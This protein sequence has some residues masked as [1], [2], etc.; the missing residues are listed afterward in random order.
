MIFKETIMQKLTITS[1]LL[2]FGLLAMSANADTPKDD[3]A[4]AHSF[5]A[6]ML[7]GKWECVGHYNDKS[8]KNTSYERSLMHFTDKGNYHYDGFVADDMNGIQDVIDMELVGEYKIEGDIFLLKS[9]K[10]LRYN[11]TNPRYNR[12]YNFED[13]LNNSPKFSRYQIVRLTDTLFENRYLPDMDD[14][15]DDSDITAYGTCRRLA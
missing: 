4:T 8:L 2:S 12:L 6:K 13:V 15:G 9:I 1:V 5:D 11:S 14:D 10:T 3:I 7:V